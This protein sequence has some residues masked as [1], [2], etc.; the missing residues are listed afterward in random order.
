[1]AVN[2]NQPITF[3]SK[4]NALSLNCTGIDFSEDGEQSWTC[5]P[6]A[7]LDIP[8][9]FARQDVFLQVEASPFLVPE[10]VSIQNVF[11]FLSGLFAGFYAL[12]GH[13]MRQFPVNRSV[14]S[15]RTTRL[16][17]VIPTAVSPSKL[18][19]S[20]DLRELGIC[21]SSITFINVT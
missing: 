18:R 3:G 17:L 10:I 13:T 20:E 1:M 16:A 8:L 19:M 9:P 21:L 4:G 2:Y 14:I 7:E 12:T 5:A 15:G 11:V 6:V